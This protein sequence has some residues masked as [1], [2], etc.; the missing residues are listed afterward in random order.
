M[1]TQKEV[2]NLAV[3]VKDNHKKYFAKATPEEVK[4]LSLYGKDHQKKYFGKTRFKNF[5]NKTQKEL[6]DLV[7]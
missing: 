6:E 1:E 7:V 2:H 3:Y 4:D 5:A